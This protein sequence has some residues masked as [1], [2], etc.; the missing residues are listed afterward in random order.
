MSKRA[1]FT[2][3]ELMVVIAIIATLVAIAIPNLL[4]ARIEANEAAAVGNLRVIIGAEAAY[5]SANSRYTDT[6]DSLANPLP[7]N[8]P[9][10]LDGDWSQAR[11]GYQFIL[12]NKPGGYTVHG[13]AVQYGVTGERGFYTDES[14]VIRY[15][16]NADADISC[17]PIGSGT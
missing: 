10:F 8:S 11:T 3:I 2:L 13:N 17:P 6:F 4:R 15:R 9:K 16:K 12:G 1:G 7:A 14:G 5:H